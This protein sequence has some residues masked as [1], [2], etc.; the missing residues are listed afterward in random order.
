MFNIV[1][2]ADTFSYYYLAD[3]INISTYCT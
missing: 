1:A 2:Y 3:G